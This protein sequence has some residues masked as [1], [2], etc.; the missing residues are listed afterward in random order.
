MSPKQRTKQLSHQGYRW[1]SLPPYMRG[2][3]TFQ[4]NKYGALRNQHLWGTW[5][6]AVKTATRANREPVTLEKSF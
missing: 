4:E 5:Q 1:V 3:T 2:G 6:E